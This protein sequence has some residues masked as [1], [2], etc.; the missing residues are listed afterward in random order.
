MEQEGEMCHSHMALNVVFI[1]SQ[2]TQDAVLPVGAR[3]Q[4]REC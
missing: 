4:T 2:K 3:G 1:V